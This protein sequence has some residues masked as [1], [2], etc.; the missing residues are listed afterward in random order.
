MALKNFYFLFILTIMIILTLNRNHVWFND[1]HLVTDTLKKSPQKARVN[2]SMGNVM[3]KIGDDERAIFYCKRALQLDPSYIKA[4]HHLFHLYAKNKRFAEAIEVIESSPYLF[5][6]HPEYYEALIGFYIELGR[7]DDAEKAFIKLTELKS[8]NIKHY[9]SFSIFL[10]ER[11]K[12]EKAI[13]VLQKALTVFGENSILYNNL[14]IAYAEAGM[15]KEAE[16]AYRKA[17]LLAPDAI[18]PRENLKNLLKK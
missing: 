12:P 7:F 13:N 16:E 4:R 3:E 8:V 18:E 9:I 10:I 14:G 6:D 5:I 17:I 1:Y 15:K 2:H 11:K